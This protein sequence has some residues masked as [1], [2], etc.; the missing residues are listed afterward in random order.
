MLVP[1]VEC[2]FYMMCGHLMNVLGV[3]SCEML[4]VMLFLY[5]E[6]MGNQVVLLMYSCGLVLM[7]MIWFVKI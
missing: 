7:G 6:E 4:D 2:G 5:I 3:V 1:V